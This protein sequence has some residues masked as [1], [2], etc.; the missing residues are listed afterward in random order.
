[1]VILKPLAKVQLEVDLKV[2]MP[3]T[4][5]ESVYCSISSDTSR[6]LPSA[7]WIIT[8]IAVLVTLDTGIWWVVRGVGVLGCA[9]ESN[10]D[11]PRGAV[12]GG[13]CLEA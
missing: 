11:M 9:H 6:L 5:L 8:R 10:S 3:L 12:V 2:G 1:M 7:R 4:V 13:L